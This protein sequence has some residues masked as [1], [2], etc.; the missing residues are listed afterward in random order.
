MDG[1]ERMIKTRGGFQGLS[2]Q[3]VYMVSWLVIFCGVLECNWVVPL[4]TCL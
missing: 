1:L 4:L 2:P 3:V